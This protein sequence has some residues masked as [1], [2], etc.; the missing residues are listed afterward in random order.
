MN[1]KSKIIVSVV[2]IFIVVLA[3]AGITYGYFLTRIQGNTNT[4][5]ISVTT[6][7]L[8]LVYGDG[9]TEII[10][11]EKII[12]NTVIGEKDFTVT[13][14]GNDTGYVV[15]ID[16]DGDIDN[17]IT[18]IKVTYVTS[19]TTRNGKSYSVNEETSFISNDFVYT[20]TCTIESSDSERNGTKCN[21]VLTETTLPM[22]GGIILGNDIKSG[23]IHK[24]NLTVTYLD[25]DDD[26]TDDMNKGFNAQINIEDIKRINPYSNNTKSLAYNIINNSMLK[27]NV[28]ELLSTPE[29]K[30]AESISSYLTGKVIKKTVEVASYEWCYGESIDEA[31]D[32]ENPIDTCTNDLIDKWLYDASGYFDE[33][34]T[35]ETIQVK[36][37]DGDKPM[38]NEKEMYHEKTLSITQDDY[39]TSYY[40]RGDVEDNYVNFAGMCWR[41]VR[42]EG[43]GSTKLILEDQYAECDDTKENDKGKDNIVYTGSWDIPAS[44]GTDLTI[45][46]GTGKPF[47]V[48]NFGYDASTGKSVADYLNPITES[49]RAMVNAFKYFQTNNLKNYMEQL[50]SGNWCYNDVAYD[51]DVGTNIINKQSYYDGTKTGFFYNDSYVRLVGKNKKPSLKCNGTILNKYNDN[52]DMYV[53]TL[54][55]DEMIFAGGKNNKENLN[56]YLI[57]KAPNAQSLWFCSLSLYFWSGKSDNTFCVG[58]SGN[59]GGNTVHSNFSN[60]RPSVILESG[61]EIKSELTDGTK[62]RPYEIN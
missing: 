51:D 14:T 17:G 12:P 23:D 46:P 60:F 47:N 20:L 22:S 37:C 15:L 55:A 54:T 56:Y 43:D 30:P 24:Y 13:N 31:S 53:G 57:S 7:N 11:K 33:N 49:N 48:G 18:P 38:Y 9:N 21:E 1:R 52:S 10:T 36:G 42:I 8:E 6:K 34:E 61:V 3:L 26:Q 62:E 50:K 5:S 28:T 2:G 35:I 40:Y 29:T 4:T 59:I 27:K 45:S 16:G 41:I 19:G 44:N 25:N 39:G 32:C 58:G